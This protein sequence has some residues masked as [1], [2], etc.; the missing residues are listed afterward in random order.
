MSKPYYETEE[1][2]EAENELDTYDDP[3]KLVMEYRISEKHK[4][5]KISDLEAKLADI[6]EKVKHW[7][8][9]YNERDKQFQSVRQRYHLLNKLQSN[10]D[11]KDKLHLAYMQCLELVEENERLK[12]QLAEKDKEI[13]H[14][15][16]MLQLEEDQKEFIHEEWNT[17]VRQLNRAK[18]KDSVSASKQLAISELV[19]IKR[20][21]DDNAYY[22]DEMNFGE[23][24]NEY[25]DNQIEELKK[26]MK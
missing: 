16:R 18:D 8:D 1:Y 23:E 5:N 13:K 26:E 17:Y 24:I 21:I 9:L 12:Q 15:K 4:G 10:Y 14:L 20:Y 3:V 11:K 7:H 19:K 22:I 6:E 25:I 2:S